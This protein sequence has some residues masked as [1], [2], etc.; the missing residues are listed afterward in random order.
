MRGRFD[1]LVADGGLIRRAFRLE[2]DVQTL[3][4][5]VILLDNDGVIKAY[6]AGGSGR[7]VTLPA[8]TEANDGTM[9]LIINLSTAGEVLTIKNSGATT[10]LA[11]ASGSMAV[12]IASGTAEAP[13]TR[14]WQVFQLGGEDLTITDDLSI[15]GD[16][17]V[18]GVT[19]LNGNVNIGNSATDKVRFFAATLTVQ[20]TLTCTA[21][22]VIG[23]TTI[24]QV[25]TSGKWAFASSTAAIALVTRAQQMQ[26]DLE[27]LMTRLENYGLLAV[28]G[29]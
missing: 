16:L 2:S 4:G 26:V 14:E 29:N 28:S 1:D 22:T 13:G 7:N 20:Q 18:T 8:R 21:T 19:T 3:G 11:L 9:R 10:L 5:N 25:A 12:V 17:A 27:K 6:D 24:S 23:T 15:T